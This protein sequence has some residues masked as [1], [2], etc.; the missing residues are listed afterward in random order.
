MPQHQYKEVSLEAV[1]AKI[2]ELK[3]RNAMEPDFG[4]KATKRKGKHAQMSPE[5]KEEFK[6][7]K[8]RKDAGELE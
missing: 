1:R 8:R 4:R 5:E 6:E 7:W 3:L 2:A